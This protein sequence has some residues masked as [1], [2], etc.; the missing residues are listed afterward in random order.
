ME[1]TP[2]LRRELGVFDLVLF[3]LA[4]GFS[5]RWIATAAA[6]GPSTIAV[7]IFACL[8]FFLPLAGCVLELSSRYPQE[9]GLYVWTQRAFGDFPGFLAAWT[10]WMSNLPF[11]PAVLYFG[12]GSMLFAVGRRGDPLINNATYYMLF[13]LGWLALITVLNI[14]GLKHGKWLNNCCAMGAWI[15]IAV[16]LALAAIFARHFGSATSFA[17]GRLVP[18]A[19]L[20]SA[21]FWSTI[22]F[23][24]GGAETGSFMGEEIKDARRTIPRSLILAGILIAGCY[25]AG[26]IAMLVAL[27]SSS[28]T[29]VGGFVSAISLMCG[30]LGL[31]WLVAPVALMV[32]LNSVGGAAV[33]LSS[34]SRLPFVAGIDHYLPR[35]FGYVHPRWRTPWVAIGAYGVAG[36]VCALLGQAGTS[37]RSAYD[38]LVSMSIISYFIP[39]VFLFAAMM[40]LQ[41]EPVPKGAFRI[42]G[43][44]PVAIALASVGLLTTLLTI[45]LSVIPPDEE[46]NKPLAIAKV[47]GST[48]FL[49]VAGV[50]VY[51]VSRRRSRRGG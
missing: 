3:Y 7:W 13:A 25:I 6:G 33:Y 44:R 26:T 14:L 10:Y 51:S 9:G 4:G 48:L 45:V 43:G 18:H 41:R 21:I 47:V 46:P 11:F 50:A 5:L 8:C 22:F 1:K 27:P 23:A 36:M 37:V 31:A 28:I 32:V 34:A 30:K 24:F 17:A 39:F 12:A 42:P 16:L 40:R 19:D 20:K 35:V 2:A 38:V 15:P 49:I 29:G